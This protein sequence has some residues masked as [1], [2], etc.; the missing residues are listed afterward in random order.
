MTNNDLR[1]LTNEELTERSKKGES[2]EKRFLELVPPERL[3]LIHKTGVE[4]FKLIFDR[5]LSVAETLVLVN[6]MKDS[7]VESMTIGDYQID[8]VPMPGEQD[9]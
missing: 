9:T 6:G 3:A 1:K 7:F 4:L 5:G 2:D 8:A